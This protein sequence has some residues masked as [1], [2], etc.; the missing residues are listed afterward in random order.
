MTGKDYLETVRLKSL[1]VLEQNYYAYDIIA[2][3]EAGQKDAQILVTDE[4]LASVR[5]SL[6]DADRIDYFDTS[7][8]VE[9]KDP[10][11]EFVFNCIPAS[12]EKYE[13]AVF[14]EHL[15]KLIEWAKGN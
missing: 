3:F 4:D 8:S 15:G 2:A 5:L 9:L 13:R 14:I 6:P 7:T 1:E 10:M 11:E 12:Y